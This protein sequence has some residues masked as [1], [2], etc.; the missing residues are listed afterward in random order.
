MAM[1]KFMSIQISPLNWPIRSCDL[2][3]LDYFLYGYVKAH[4][5]I[6]KPTSIDALEEHIESFIHEIPAEILERVCEKW[7][8]R[9]DYLERS[10]GQHLHEII[11]K[12]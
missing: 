9:M 4:V 12:H 7:T 11:F 5:N 10:H 8:K 1:L 3:Y 2:T 6:D